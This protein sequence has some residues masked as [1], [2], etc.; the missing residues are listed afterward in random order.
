MDFENCKN[1]EH[2]LQGPG[3]FRY[4]NEN[5][6]GVALSRNIPIGDSVTIG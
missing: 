3:N 6:N 4:N 1:I 5:V 2:K